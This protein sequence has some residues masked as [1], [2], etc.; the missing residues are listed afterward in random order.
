MASLP[1]EIAALLAPGEAIL[2]QAQPRPYVFM[3]RG[4]PA[5]FY[6]ITWSVLGAYWYHAAMLA[7]WEGWW[8]LAP[9]F[10]LP[11]ILCGF[12]FFFYPI[13]LGARARHT[14]YVVTDRRIFIARLH[15]KKPPELRVFTREEM[16]PPQ[17]VK[18]LDGF[19]ELILTRSAQGKPYL[20][21]RLESG[22]FGI[23]DG[24]AA[25]AAIGAVMN[26]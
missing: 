11:F 16:G 19:D 20:V 21:P 23:E 7:P 5:I 8:K 24:S 2:W 17:L 13:N 25:A 4:L 14:W 9:H 10:S 6:G 22:F 12:S 3:L 26:R 15:G 1:K 18:R